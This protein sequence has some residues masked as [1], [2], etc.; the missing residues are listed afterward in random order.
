MTLWLQSPYAQ[1][2]AETPVRKLRIEDELW[3]RIAAQ[4][5]ENGETAS[6]YIRRAIVRALKEDQS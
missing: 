6:G 3:E 2:M 4:A 1:G 5:N